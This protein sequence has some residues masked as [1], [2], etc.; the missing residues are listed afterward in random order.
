MSMAEFRPKFL[1]GFCVPFTRGHRQM[2]SA[3]QG[4]PTPCTTE[5]GM[6]GL[7]HSCIEYLMAIGR[8]GG[9][10]KFYRVSVL[11]VLTGPRGRTALA[12]VRLCGSY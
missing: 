2:P 10:L 4:A 7:A 8:Y 11:A 3:E 12:V 6:D 5:A 1:E 9:N